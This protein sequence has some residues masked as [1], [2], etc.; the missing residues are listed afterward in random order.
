MRDASIATLDGWVA[1]MGDKPLPVLART[2]RELA[3]LRE[4]G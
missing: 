4:A 3:V 2:T 1:Y